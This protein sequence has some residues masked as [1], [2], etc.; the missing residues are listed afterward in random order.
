MKIILSKP[1]YD[2]IMER[3]ATLSRRVDRL[4]EIGDIQII[5]EQRML[6]KI[7]DILQSRYNA[8]KTLKSLKKPKP[9]EE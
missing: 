4:S 6:S 5:D 7:A 8:A 3:L 2:G 9:K 1:D